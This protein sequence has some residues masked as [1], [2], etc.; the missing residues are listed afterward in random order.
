M[1]MSA[2]SASSLAKA[3]VRSSQSRTD[4]DFAAALAAAAQTSA[5]SP[6]K[7]R[8]PLLAAKLILP[9]R[10]NVQQLA[11]ALA[12]RLSAR[13]SAAGLS[14]TPAASFSVDSAGGI[15]V[16]GDRTDL[17]AIEKLVSSD[18]RLQ[19][20][21]RDTNAI[22][23]HAYEIENGGHL[24]FQRAYRLSSDPQEIVAQYAYLFSGQQRAAATSVA[25]LGGVVSVVADGQS[26]V[27]S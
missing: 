19:R 17:A 27:S 18:D 12:Q 4:A 13:F 20:A 11:S 5:A 25:F 23:S 10:Q 16:S 24:Q 2:V 6:A 15:H 1:D 9:T 7:V 26:W 21:I 8:S 22:A 3:G 14:K